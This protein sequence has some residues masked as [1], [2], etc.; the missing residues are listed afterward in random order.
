M[1]ETETAT[2]AETAAAE[3]TAA[4]DMKTKTMNH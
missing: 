4:D 1:K 3:I 2:Q